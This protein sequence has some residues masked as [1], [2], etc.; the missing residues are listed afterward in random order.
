MLKRQGKKSLTILLPREDYCSY[1]V[2]ILGDIFLCIY[3]EFLKV[4]LGWG[5]WVA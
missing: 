1:L 4:R 2:Y 5:T 3:T